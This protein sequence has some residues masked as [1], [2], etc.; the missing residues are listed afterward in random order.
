MTA[1]L[2]AMEDFAAVFGLLSVFRYLLLRP[3]CLTK[4]RLALC[5][6]LLLTPAAVVFAFPELPAPYDGVPDFLAS[7]LYVVCAL[8]LQKKP[9]LL[10]TVGVSLFY[11]FTVEV[12]WG[13][14][15]YYTTR[16]LWLEYAVC[17]ALYVLS[18]AG[19]RLAASRVRGNALH[20]FVA[21]IPKWVFAVLILFEVM[22]YYKAYGQEAQRFDALFLISS[23]ALIVTFLLMMARMLRLS[24]RENELLRQMALQKEYAQEA[25]TDDET[26]RRFRHDYK[27]HMLVIYALLESGRADDAQRYLAAMQ[28]PV[29]GALARIKSG[30]FVADTLLN[31]AA[32]TASQAQIAFHFTGSIPADGIRSD[33]LCV[34]LSNLL[35]NALK[36]CRTA[37]GERQIFAE[38]KTAQGNLLLSVTNSV[39][40]GAAGTRR[41]ESADSR[42]HGL[43]L[44]NVQRTAKKYGGTLQTGVRD[45]VFCAD[46]LLK[47]PKPSE[48]PR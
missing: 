27:N 2:C 28:E 26:L 23:A 6:A 13:L 3:L 33:D 22:C 36:A 17:T 31:H 7:V 5:A 43:G 15:A 20:R 10:S 30:N 19:I 14:I 47:I 1:A 18:G 11:T 25:I 44:K 45:G 29:Q 8:L 35:D 41:A 21:A 24:H 40:T 16:A 48:E 37:D 34:I 12:F 32:Q 42:N 9:K 39:G 46:V 4:P 38:A